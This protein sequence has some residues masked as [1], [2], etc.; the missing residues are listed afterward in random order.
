MPRTRSKY[1]L[2]D[3]AQQVIGGILL[4]GPFVVTEEVWNIASQ[5]ST[6]QSLGNVLLVATIGYLGLYY[7]DKDRHAEEE[8]DIVG[9]PTRFISLMSVSFLSV[10]TLIYLFNAPAAFGASQATTI[11]VVTIGG[12]FSVVG[13][14]TADSLF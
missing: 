2:K 9:I 12:L 6:L 1:V 14:A 4:S 5:M 3:S 10:L 13:A 7:A 11:K 8:A